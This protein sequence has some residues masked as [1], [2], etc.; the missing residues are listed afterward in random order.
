[1]PD[2]AA[3]NRRVAKNTA[4]LY[5]RMLFLTLINLYTVRIT[6]EVLGPVDYGVYTVI[7]SVVLSLS[8]LTASMTSATQRYLSFHLGKKDY[9][10]YSRTFSLLLIGFIAISAIIFVVAEVL[11]IF[12]VNDWLN[13]PTDRLEA[14][15]WVYQTAVIMFILSLITIPYASSIIANE[16][17]SAFAYISIADG[18]MKLLLVYLLLRSPIDRLI[19]YGILTMAQ[20]AVTL[21][22]H[23][24]YCSKVFTYCKVRWV[25]DKALFRELTAYTG[26]NLIGSV[27]GML[28]T[29]GLSILLNIFF[30]PLVNTAKGIADRIT[31][32][33][34]QF[35]TNF[36]M[37]VNPQIVKSYASGDKDRMIALALKGSRFSYFLL[38]AISTPLIVCMP[39]LLG[40]W[41]V[42][43]VVTDEMI[44]FSQLSLLFCLV[45]SLEEPITQM[46]RATGNIRDYQIR[47]G[48]LSLML[49][50]I[51]WLFFESGASAVSSMWVCI[52]LFAIIQCVRIAVACRQVGLI[53]R[54]YLKEVVLP[55]AAVTASG[56]VVWFF[57]IK[58]SLGNLWISLIVKG[59]LS[60]VGQSM[61]ILLV[62]MTSS[63]RAFVIGMLRR[64]HQ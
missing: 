39:E 49:I 20:T 30:G 44:Q 54:N 28:S 61:A 11:G 2:Y 22:L 5:F 57:C 37:A 6:L 18:V 29:Q 51:V 48:V 32:V 23:I 41:L 38:L 35:S 63:D 24:I 59:L 60:F 17:M 62:G 12:F 64:K 45:M 13:I 47:V 27:S 9:A 42:G 55:I 34:R 14:A 36:Y 58:L 40:L 52:V 56:A 16:R 31:N 50:P 8:F 19:Y 46:I 43:D 10:A 33:V 26:W 25:W 4:F 15:K 7:A 3:T 1:M 53:P 21:A